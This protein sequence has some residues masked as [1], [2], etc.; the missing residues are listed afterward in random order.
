VAKFDIRTPGVTVQA[1]T[2][3]GGNLQKLI[4]ARE[5]SRRTR[6]LVAVQPTRGVDLATMKFIHRQLLELRDEGSGILLISTELDEVLSLSDRIAVIY[7]GEILEIVSGE[8]A[9]RER[10]GLLMAGMKPSLVRDGVNGTIRPNLAE[11][12]RQAPQKEIDQL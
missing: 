1:R 12:S 6:V 3:S 2:L 7:E 10:I 4:L 9:N 8:T 11:G 5:V